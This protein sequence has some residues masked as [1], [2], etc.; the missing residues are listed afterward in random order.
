MSQRHLARSIVMQSLYQWDFKGKPTSAILAIVAEQMA[1]FGMGLEKE[2]TY[3]VE[4]VNG[5][6][7]RIADVDK[8]I[9]EHAPNWS[10]EQMSIV[11]RNIL[12]IG[13]YELYFNKDIPAKVAI[14]EAIEIAKSYGG[15]SSG[16]FVNGILGAMYK[17]IEKI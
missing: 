9:T 6:L 4:T 7:D 10:I 13:V 8:K 3:V 17:E 1:E 12:R 5:I 16:K 15:P 14:N 2:E 11:D